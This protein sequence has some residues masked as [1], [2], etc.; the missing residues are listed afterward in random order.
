V[1]PL[2][3]YFVEYARR[4]H[5]Y[6]GGLRGQPR[7]RVPRQLLSRSS[8]NVRAAAAK[9]QTYSKEEE[10]EANKNASKITEPRGR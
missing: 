6:R 7:F 5:G 3:Q 10:A 1:K 8:E 4:M 2:S 9:R